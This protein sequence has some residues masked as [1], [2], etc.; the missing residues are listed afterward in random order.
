MIARW[1]W[2]LGQMTKRLWFRASLFSLAGIATALVATVFK[3]FVPADLPARIGADS[4]DKILAIIASSMLAVTTFSLSTMVSA[5]SAASSGV[6]PRATSLVMED[7]T[8]QNALATFIGSFLFSLVGIIA[9]STGAYGAQGRVVL[10]AVTIVMIILIVSTLLR[11]IDHLSKLGRVGETIDRVEAAALQSLK[12]RAQWPYM[13]AAPYPAELTAPATARA[14]GSNE[15]GYVQHIDIAA[16]GALGEKHGLQI[17][18]DILPGAFVHLGARMAWFIEDSVGHA[19]TRKALDPDALAGDIRAAVTVGLRRS[20]EQDPRFGISVL[21]EIASRALSPAT[22][23]SGTV[24]DVIGRGVRCFTAWHMESAAEATSRAIDPHCRRVHVRG[25]QL[26]D[27]FDDFFTLVARDGAGLLEVD[28]RMIKALIS[29]N[30]ISP[31]T[32]GAQCRL[33]A[34]WLIK[35]ADAALALDEDK[36]RLI[37]LAAPLLS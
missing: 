18:V 30:D 37:A 14:V 9:L 33:H 2:A 26:A 4:V 5:Y 3:D 15:T 21:A 28:I 25:L 7:T 24:I 22:N 29:L 11:W 27:L 36:Q 19:L 32:F 20:F 23:D 13:G 12:N 10:F 6:T 34:R 8:T 17:Y 31:E 16:L 35:R 1:R